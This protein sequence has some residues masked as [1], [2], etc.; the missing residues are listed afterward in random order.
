MTRNQ[1]DR[2]LQYKA[3][4][5]TMLNRL[6]ELSDHHFNEN[7]DC[8]TWASVADISRIHELIKAASDCAFQ[9]GEYAA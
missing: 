8:I 9:E 4:I 2:F 1:V 5:D 7:P 3:E 6:Q